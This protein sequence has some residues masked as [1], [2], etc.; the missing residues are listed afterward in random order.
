MQTLESQQVKSYVFT[1]CMVMSWIFNFTIFNMLSPLQFL[2]GNGGVLYVFAVS[3]ILGATFVF[4][5]VPETMGKSFEEISQ[6]MQR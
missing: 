1:F 2:F 3:S 4:F 5:Y 6:L